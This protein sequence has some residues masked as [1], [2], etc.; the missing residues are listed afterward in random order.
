[1]KFDEKEIFPAHNQGVPGSSPGGPTKH[2]SQLIV[3]QFVEI[4]F[5]P[6]NHRRVPF[7]I[8]ILVHQQ[9]FYTPNKV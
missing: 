2:K 7:E 3:Y 8:P 4:F 5:I 9:I 1:M 6:K